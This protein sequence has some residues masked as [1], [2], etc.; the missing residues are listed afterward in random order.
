[1]KSKLQAA[2]AKAASTAKAL[3]SKL[4]TS[5]ANEVRWSAGGAAVGAAG[6]AVVIGG[7]GVALLGTAVAVSGAAVVGLAGAALG[8]KIG[9][10]IDRRRLAKTASEDQ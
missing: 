5:R 1:M 8:N 10:E 9:S 4:P 6:G 7:M 3:N 2:A